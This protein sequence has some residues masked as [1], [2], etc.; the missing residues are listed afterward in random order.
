MLMWRA[1]ICELD[2][3]WSFVGSKARQH[4]RLVRV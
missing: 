4:W 1:L 3:Q 2:E